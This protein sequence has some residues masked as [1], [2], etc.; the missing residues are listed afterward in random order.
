MKKPLNPDEIQYIPASTPAAAVQVP[1]TVPC[2]ITPK[3]SGPNLAGRLFTPG[4]R[5]DQRISEITALAELRGRLLPSMT[6]DDVYTLIRDMCD[7]RRL[8]VAR[9]DELEAERVGDGG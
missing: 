3:L 8:D 7:E 6:L 9:L 1:D 5:R 4:D 2:T